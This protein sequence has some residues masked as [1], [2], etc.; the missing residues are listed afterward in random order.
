MTFE[1]CV[2]ASFWDHIQ[3]IRNTELGVLWKS[4]LVAAVNSFLLNFL[5]T[6]VSVATF[7]GYVLLGHNLTAA[8]AFT[9]LALFNV[10]SLCCIHAC[11]CNE[12]IALSGS[13][14]GHFCTIAWPSALAT[15]CRGTTHRLRQSPFLFSVPTPLLMRLMLQVAQAEASP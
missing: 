14:D 10:R 5:P 11:I 8:E 3:G 9:S 12:I 1:S 15:C 4:F 7:F 6:F 2:Q 13:L